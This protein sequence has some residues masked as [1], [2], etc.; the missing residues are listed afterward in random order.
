MP[1]PLAEPVGR[2]AVVGL[3]ALEPTRFP[4]SVFKLLSSV[5]S[6]LSLESLV[7]FCASR[8]FGIRSLRLLISSALRLASS[9]RLRSAFFNVERTDSNSPSAESS[10]VVRLSS[11]AFS[12]AVSV[13]S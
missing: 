6:S 7:S 13:F 9:S 3:G 1:L 2:W 4:I 10:F 12:A 5:P 8:A 11:A